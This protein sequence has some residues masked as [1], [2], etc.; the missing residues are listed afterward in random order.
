[1]SHQRRNV[2]F[3]LIAVIFLMASSSWASDGFTQKDREVIISLK[4]KVEE[5]DKRFEQ[6]EKRFEQIDK[7][8]EQLDKRFE[9][10]DKRFEQVDKRFGELISFLWM[11]VT[12]FTAITVSTISF[13]LWDRRSMIRP[14]E[15]RV[16]EIEEGKVDKVISSLRTLAETDSKVAEILKRYNLL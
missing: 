8:F 3:L 13:A 7:R 12:L 15:R 9:Q 16:K 5:I 2:V 4:V 10:I 11:I 1:M 14:F 6:I